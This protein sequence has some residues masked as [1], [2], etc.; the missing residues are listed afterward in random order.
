[1]TTLHDFGSVLGW[2]LYTS[3]EL[4]Q[5]HGHGSWLECEVALSHLGFEITH[6]LT[7]EG[8]WKIVIGF[9]HK[10]QKEEENEPSR[11][12]LRC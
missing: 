11:I 9:P 1:M 4:S 7:F 2:P 12:G 10:K 3:F 8:G 5:F 6:P